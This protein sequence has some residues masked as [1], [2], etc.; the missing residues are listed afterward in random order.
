MISFYG[1][2]LLAPRQTLEL[3]D[4]PLSSVCYCLRTIFKA[5]LHI[6]GRTFIHNMKTPFAMVTGT[7]FSRKQHLISGIFVICYVLK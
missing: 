2:E 5:I 6:G 7:H 3:Q 1:E 4:H